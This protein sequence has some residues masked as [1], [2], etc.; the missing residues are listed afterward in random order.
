MRTLAK[1]VL[2]VAATWLILRG[3]GMGMAQ[4]W[5]VDWSQ[6]RPDIPNLALS[7]AFL[8]VSFAAGGWLWSRMLPEFGEPALP[9]GLSS[10]IQLV[11]N[12]GRYIP[13]KVAQVAGLALLCRRAALSPVRGTAAAVT[14]QIASLLAAFVVGIPAVVSGPAGLDDPRILWAAVLV[15]SSLLAFL[16]SG[17]AGALVRWILRRAGNTED[18]PQG[19]GRRLHIWLPACAVMWAVHGAVIVFLARGLGMT[20]SFT[21]ATSAF[22]AAYFLGYVFVFAPAGIGV[23]EASLAALLASVVGTEAGW[24]LAIMQRAWLTAVEFVAALGAAAFLWRRGMLGP[25]VRRR[26]AVPSAPRS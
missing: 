13:G 14:V 21:T 3:A 5:T 16:W 7:L 24:A 12:L 25:E 10:A 17:S 11:A 8:C 6:L 23:R 26:S 22:A 2:T 20:I 9:V 4:A 15:F 18:L 1:L 19:V